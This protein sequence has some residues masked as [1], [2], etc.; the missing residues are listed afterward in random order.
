M[1]PEFRVGDKVK[2]KPNSVGRNGWLLADR[3]YTI[4]DMYE[5]VGDEGTIHWLYE[6]K[7]IPGILWAGWRFERV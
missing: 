3:T 4:T 1:L 2:V 5:P 6:L 7:E